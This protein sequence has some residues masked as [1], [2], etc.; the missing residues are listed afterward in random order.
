MAENTSIKFSI[1][2]LLSLSSLFVSFEHC[3]TLKFVFNNSLMLCRNLQKVLHEEVFIF[4]PYFCS[5]IFHKTV[6]RLSHAVQA[7]L[8][9]SN[10]LGHNFNSLLVFHCILSALHSNWLLTLVVNS[11][12]NRNLTRNSLHYIVSSAFRFNYMG[13][14]IYT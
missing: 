2:N 11:T 7:H 8:H 13:E 4:G 5:G 3:T 14:N 12:F 9:P 6:D 10:S 1:S